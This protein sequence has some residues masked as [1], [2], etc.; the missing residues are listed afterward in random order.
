MKKTPQRVIDLLT[1][2]VPA[3]I[4][5]Y[6]FSLKTGI[7]ALSLERYKAGVTEPNQASMKA[8]AD[9]FG[10]TVAYLRGESDSVEVGPLGEQI[11]PVLI[12]RHKSGDV[13]LQVQNKAIRIPAEYVMD[14]IS[15]ILMVSKEQSTPQPGGDNRGEEKK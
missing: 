13:I 7:N 9:Y 1:E 11:H 4:S 15:G 12:G 14:T 6:K 3:K 10:V 2:E 5:G 8:L